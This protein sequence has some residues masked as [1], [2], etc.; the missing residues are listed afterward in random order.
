MH[1]LRVARSGLALTTS[2][3]IA[4]ADHDESDQNHC[5][6]GGE[7]CA[8]TSPVE[9]DERKPVIRLVEGDLT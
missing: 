7:P 1:E 8:K 6:D 3:E 2:L 5:E 4:A 9:V